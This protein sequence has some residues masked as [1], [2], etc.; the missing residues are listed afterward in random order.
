MQCPLQ[1]LLL[2][3]LLSANPDVYKRQLKV[4]LKLID[5]ECDVVVSCID[6]ASQFTVPKECLRD[7]GLTLSL[8]HIWYNTLKTDGNYCYV[9][10]TVY[11]TVTKVDGGAL[12]SSKEK[13]CTFNRS[14]LISY[15]AATRW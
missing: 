4:L 13:L 6:A 7:C 1:M 10:I 2:L 15:T 3:T 5:G 8:I 11:T 14:L 9:D 12:K